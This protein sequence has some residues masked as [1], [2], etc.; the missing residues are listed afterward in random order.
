MDDQN[1]EECQK[2][3]KKEVGNQEELKK[4]EESMGCEISQQK[5]AA[6]KIS[7]L[8]MKWFHSLQAPYAKW[9]RNLHTLKSFSAHTMSWP[10]ASTPHFSTVGHIFGALPRAQIMH[11][12]CQFESWEVRSP[13]LQMVHDLELK[14]K[15]Y[16]CLKTNHATMHLKRR[17]LSL[18]SH[19]W[20]LSFH[21]LP[22]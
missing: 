10:V 6:V 22:P 5:W 12:I 15:S 2:S 3:W 11:T 4:H 7:P 9:L 1:Q 16:G 20:S 21:F 19:T 18:R 14:R 13:M 17:A 8:A